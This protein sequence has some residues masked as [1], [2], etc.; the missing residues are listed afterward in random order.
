MQSVYNHKWYNKISSYKCFV[1][2]YF[3]VNQNQKYYEKFFF[4][5]VTPFLDLHEATSFLLLVYCKKWIQTFVN[6]I[7]FF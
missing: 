3:Q 1:P 5:F 2:H 7:P 6:I 4:K